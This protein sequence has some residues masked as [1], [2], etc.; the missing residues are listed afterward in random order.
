MKRKSHTFLNSALDLQTSTLVLHASS[1]LCLLSDRTM[2]G[3]QQASNDS[4]EWNM[5]VAQQEDHDF[6]ITPKTPVGVAPKRISMGGFI[7]C[8]GI[9]QVTWNKGGQCTA[10]EYDCVNL[11]GTTHPEVFKRGLQIRQKIPRLERPAN[12]V[13]GNSTSTWCS[14]R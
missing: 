12:F 3:Q 10:P 1:T 5:I 4:N 2:A 6:F 13:S 11:R 8:A 7:Q 9:D 14:V